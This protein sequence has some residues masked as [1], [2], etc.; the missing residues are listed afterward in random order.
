MKSYGR[1][2]SVN[3]KAGR[4]KTRVKD[5]VEIVETCSHCWIKRKH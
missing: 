5:E 2:N 1:E 4:T 3:V